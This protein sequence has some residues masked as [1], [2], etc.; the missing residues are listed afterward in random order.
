MLRCAFFTVKT[1]KK[2][3]FLLICINVKKLK[4]TIDRQK[5]KRYNK[6]PPAKRW[7]GFRKAE[8]TFLK[9]LSKK[10]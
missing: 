3:K 9:K 8:N 1:V 5:E 6:N 10:Y 4:K 2:G 7:S